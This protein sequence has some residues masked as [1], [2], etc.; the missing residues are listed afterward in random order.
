MVPGGTNH[1]QCIIW[2]LKKYHKESKANHIWRKD[3]VMLTSLA[4]SFV[5][6]QRD[7]ITSSH[8][9]RIFGS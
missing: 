3:G 1:L 6:R 2:G 8:L 9:T 7:V 5:A 4:G